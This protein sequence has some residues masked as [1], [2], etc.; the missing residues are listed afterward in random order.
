MTKKGSFISKTDV[1]L[2]DRD[3]LYSF[4]DRF[5]LVKDIIIRGG[6][7]V[8]RNCQNDGGSMI[9]SRPMQDSVSVENALYA[10]PRILEAAAVGVPDERLGELV[11]AVV[12][13]KPPFQGRVTEAALI[14]L[15]RK[16]YDSLGIHTWVSLNA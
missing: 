11:A 14:A 7:N 6:E 3:Y 15:A 2:T 10:D 1:G 13:V 16:R 9:Y 8:V 5:I 12:S 4:T